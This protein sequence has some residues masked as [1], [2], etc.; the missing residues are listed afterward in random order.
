MET[1]PCGAIH[2]PLTVLTTTDIRLN[3]TPVKP[4]KAGI[5]LV[6]AA[7]LYCEMFKAIELVFTQGPS[8]T[9]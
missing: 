6:K 3:G 9:V 8:V 1:M 4:H 7:V 2:K 5:V